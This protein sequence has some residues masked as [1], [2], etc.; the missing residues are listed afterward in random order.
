MSTEVARIDDELHRVYDGACWAGPSFREAI[1]N[2]TP[3]AAVRRHPPFAHSIWELVT[4][5]SAWVEV[6][7]RRVAEWT[8]VDLS[9]ADNFPP[10]SDPGPAAWAAVLDLLDDR[11]RALRDLVAGLDPD[12]L[13]AVAPGTDYPV[14]V[15][16]HGTAQHITYHA[17]QIALLK[18]LG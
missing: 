15:M 18:R 13:D 1:A 5:T 3:G 7:R 9:D 14:A 17:G 12:R 2:V 8:K 4:H 6:V 16:L 11:V 10:V